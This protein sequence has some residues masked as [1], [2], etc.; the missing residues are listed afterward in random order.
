MSVPEGQR[1]RGKLAVLNDIDHGIKE[2]KRIKYY[3]R[4]MDDLILIH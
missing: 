2:R 4:Y 3:V 1:S